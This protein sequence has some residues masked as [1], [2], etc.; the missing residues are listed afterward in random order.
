[1]LSALAPVNYRNVTAH[2]NTFAFN[3]LIKDSVS[4]NFPPK[5]TIYYN[6][7][8]YSFTYPTAN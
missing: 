4:Y 3:Y 6:T 1:M 7:V 2:Y 5:A 8:Y